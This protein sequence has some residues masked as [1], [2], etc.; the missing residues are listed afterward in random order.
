MKLA[1]LLAM[2]VLAG[3]A[4]AADPPVPA[5]KLAAPMYKN[6]AKF[7]AGTS[8]THR[9]T[10]DSAGQKSESTMTSTLLELTA[11][12][13]TVEVVLVSKA[14]GAEFKA[15]PQKQE[16]TRTVDAPP[17][18]KPDAKP[19]KVEGLVEE[20]TKT[21]TVAGKEYKASYAKIR[22]K[23]GDIDVTS[24]TWTSEEVPGMVLKMLSTVGGKYAT[25]STMELVEIKKP[26]A[27]K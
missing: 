20:G 24:E 10:T 23:T 4:P 5:E 2:A 6:W 11:E 21:V 22:Q 1:A 9:M 8:V 18:Y 12:K 26:A 14:G 7:P 25:T 27:K 19:A 13:A 15:P 17:G 16:L 3:T